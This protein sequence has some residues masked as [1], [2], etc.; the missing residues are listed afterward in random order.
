MD[1]SAQQPLYVAVTA[2]VDPDANRAV[3]DREDAVSPGGEPC[4]EA[5][6][7]GLAALI[8]HLEALSLPA[9]LFW[10]GRALKNL[11]MSRPELLE[12]ILENPALEHACH[13]LRHED[14]S[15]RWT[16]HP[17]GG[18]RTAHLMRE[19]GA[20]IH[21]ITGTR[22]EGFR[23]PYCNL[24]DELV[25]CLERM[26]YLYDASLTRE[27]APSWGLRPYRPEGGRLQELALVR[28][29]DREGKPISGYLWQLFEGG[30]P[31]G[32]YVEMVRSL[33]AQYPGGLLQLALHPW[34]LEVNEDGR[35]LPGAASG[36]LADL[37]SA[38]RG[39]ERVE[40]IS[41]RAYLRNEARQR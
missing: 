14:F 25:D 31:P 10:E 4:Y 34:H 39:M 22:P 24:T 30:R 6:F 11:K 20:C 13:G 38:V 15:G 18:E 19:A 28:A 2:D 21:S 29:R 1:R 41:A 26:G 17:L 8:H 16:G 35:R 32:D 33:G 23:A 12:R 40:P 36:V 5:C 27:P 37:L 7:E 3:P 9:T